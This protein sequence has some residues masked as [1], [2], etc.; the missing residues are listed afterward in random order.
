MFWKEGIVALP[1]HEPHVEAEGRRQLEQT[2]N[3]SF[4][5]CVKHFEA[6]KKCF[7]KEVGEEKVIGPMNLEIEVGKIT[8][9]LGPN[10]VGKCVVLL[11]QITYNTL[12]NAPFLQ[13]THCYFSST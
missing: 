3:L 5:N 1:T 13:G 10:G 2:N 4:K 8:T 12:Y 9:L 7:S 6:E 11:F